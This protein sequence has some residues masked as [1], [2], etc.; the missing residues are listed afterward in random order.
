M[1]AF[2]RRLGP[3]KI[4]ARVRGGVAARSQGI[5]VNAP[6]CA[7]GGG[8]KPCCGHEHRG[9]EVCYAPGCLGLFSPT[10]PSAEGAMF[11][12]ADACTNRTEL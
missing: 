10:A 2:V 4:R 1:G 7:M 3:N 6:G 9:S 8:S 5:L 12:E 11:A